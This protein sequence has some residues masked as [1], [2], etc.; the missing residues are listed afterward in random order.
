MTRVTVFVVAAVGALLVLAACNQ[1]SPVGDV[2]TQ[3]ATTVSAP[4][5]P[6]FNRWIDPATGKFYDPIIWDDRELGPEQKAAKPLPP[7]PRWAPFSSCMAD[8]GFETRNDPSEAF[9]QA[10]MD[11]LVAEV[12][13][14]R[15][16]TAANKLVN[17]NATLTGLPRAFVDCA[18]Q[19]LAIPIADF[20]KFG[21]KMPPPEDY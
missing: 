4:S 12:N 19:W 11:R 10:D 14:A 20:P 13:A 8:R 7:D 3:V 1:T 16:D 5:P 15:P 21:L 18:D 9:S 6:P 17:G 2:V